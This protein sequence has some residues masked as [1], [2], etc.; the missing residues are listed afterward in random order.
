MKFDN[1]LV[2]KIIYALQSVYIRKEKDAAH[3]FSYALG[4]KLEYKLTYIYIYIDKKHNSIEKSTSINN[5]C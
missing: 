3:D 5:I 2:L 1:W 4:T